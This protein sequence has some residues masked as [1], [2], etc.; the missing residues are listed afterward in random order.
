MSSV[1][2]EGPVGFPGATG[3]HLALVD[4]DKWRGLQ[5]ITVKIATEFETKQKEV[6]LSR[7]SAL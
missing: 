7:L 1:Q 4:Q 5:A 2:S 6:L 3:T